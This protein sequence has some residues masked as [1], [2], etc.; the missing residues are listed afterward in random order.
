M[1]DRTRFL[2]IAV[3]NYILCLKA[4]VSGPTYVCAEKATVSH[5]VALVCFHGLKLSNGE[6]IECYFLH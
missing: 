6:K 4:G 5:F 1:E 2:H 3:K